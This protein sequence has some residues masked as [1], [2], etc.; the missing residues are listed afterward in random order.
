MPRVLTH[1][2]HYLV[3]TLAS[4]ALWVELPTIDEQLAKS[5]TAMVTKL[6]ATTR[7][8]LKLQICEERVADAGCD[9]APSN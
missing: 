9:R 8:E 7:Q 4:R 3:N 1:P 2:H 6:V 5:L